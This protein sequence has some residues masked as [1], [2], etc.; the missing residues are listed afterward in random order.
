MDMFYAEKLWQKAKEWWSIE[1]THPC[2]DK[3]LRAFVWGVR[4]VPEGY[5]LVPIEP[6]KEGE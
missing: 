6:T 5:V 1:D 3:I 2:H 4:H